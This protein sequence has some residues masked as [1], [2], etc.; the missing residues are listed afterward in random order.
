M[1]KEA[2][3]PTTEAERNVRWRK[4]NEEQGS[5]IQNDSK[6]SAFWRLI[7]AIATD[8]YAELQKLLVCH[9][10]PN[11]FLKFSTGQWLDV[12]ADGVDLERKQ[13]VC[14]EGVVTV[15]RTASVGDLLIPAGT[16]IETPAINGKV[17]QVSS[18][19]DVTIPE[20][21]LS[22]ELKVKAVKAGADH[23]LGPGYFSI[24]VKPIPGVA[25]VANKGEWLSVAG[26]DEEQDEEL[27]LRCRNQFSAVGQYHHDAAYTADIASFAG[28]R[29]DYLRFEHDAP[30]GPGSANCFVMI[31]SGAPSQAFVDKI[32]GYVRDKGNH[33][34][35]DD[36]MC[37]PMPEVPNDLIVTVKPVGNLS[38]EAETALLTGVE[39]R[40]RCAFRENSAHDVTRTLPWSLFSFSRLGEELHDQLPDLQSVVFSL[41]DL[42]S[43]MNLPI[44]GTLTV[45]KG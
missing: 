27:R 31:E 8:P 39:D 21:S 11:I 18:V 5:L 45:K 1:L 35:G 4:L 23:N 32:N 17:Y 43:E 10:L 30:R 6:W 29:T 2:G 26:A 13:A 41:S 15:T 19:D 36:M 34:H 28:V 20:G 12:Y 33:G 14:T 7:T 44:L 16:L 38:A 37:F 22:G 3:M 42:T 24:L 40:V 9:A 25:A